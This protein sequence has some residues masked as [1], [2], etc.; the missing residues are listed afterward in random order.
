MRMVD[1]FY[2][3]CCYRTII[4]N[5]V[6]NSLAIHNEI[7]FHVSFFSNYN[8]PGVLSPSSSSVNVNRSR[9]Y[10]SIGG[11]R[12]SNSYQKSNSYSNPYMPGT[13]PPLLFSG[14]GYQPNALIEHHNEGQ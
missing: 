13:T 4:N 9:S 3:V 14:S 6:L 5:L 7:Y 10:G 2:V 8:I 1:I 12:S 11:A